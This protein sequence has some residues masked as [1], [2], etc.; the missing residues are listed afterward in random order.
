MTGHEPLP[1]MIDLSVFEQVLK[2]KNSLVLVPTERL[3]NQICAA[4]GSTKQSDMPA[5]R[6]PHVHSML[7]WLKNCWDEMHDL[8]LDSVTPWAMAERAQRLFFWEKAIN[9][10]NPQLATRFSRM[11]DDT[12][13]ELCSHY[14]HIENVP[15][16]TTSSRQFKV[17]SKTYAKLME[18][19]GFLQPH[20]CWKLLETNFKKH[21][22]HTYQCIYLYGFQSITPLE[23]NILNNSAD[24]CVL[25][26]PFCIDMID[27]LDDPNQHIRSLFHPK[28]KRIEG[29]DKAKKIKFNDP[30][31]ELTAA[32]TWA[33]KELKTSPNQRI[34]I[35]LPDLPNRLGEVY[36]AIDRAL[37]AS[38]VNIPVNFSAGVPLSE[39]PMIAG[40]LELLSSINNEKTLSYWLR[41]IYSPYSAFEYL[42]L[43]VKGQLEQQLRKK[44]LFS[45]TLHQ[46]VYEIE[47]SETSEDTSKATKAFRLLSTK[48]KYQADRKLTLLKFSQ[49]SEVIHGLLQKQNWPGTNPVSS[50]EYQQLSQWDRLME[51]FCGLDNLGERINSNGAVQTLISMANDHIFH[52][53]TP[54][55]SLQV[56]GLLDASGLQFNKVWVLGSDHKNL[57]KLPSINPLLPANYQKKHKLFRYDATRELVIARSLLQS[58]HANADFLICS[59]PSHRDEEQSIE[60]PLLRNIDSSCFPVSL[61]PVYDQQ[62]FDNSNQFEQTELYEQPNVPL[63]MSKEKIRGGAAILRNQFVCPFN[64]FAIHRLGAMPIDPP[65]KG[66]NKRERGILIHEILFKLWTQ[67]KNSAKLTQLS[68]VELTA[69]INQTIDLT[70]AKYDRFSS[71]LRG[72]R[73]RKLEKLQICNLIE[74]WLNKEKGREPFEVLELERLFTIKF[75]ELTLQLTV[76]RID[77]V[78]E[79]KL[80]IDYKTGTIKSRGWDPEQLREPQLPLYVLA[81]NPS[82]NGCAYAQLNADDIRLIGES[83]GLL[84]PELTEIDDWPARIIGWK[85][86]LKKLAHSFSSGNCDISIGDATAFKQQHFLLPL[87]RFIEY[88]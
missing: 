33:A 46:F 24:R 47:R 3:A 27:R 59:Y 23:R 19:N 86:G 82:S 72:P 66:I 38:D 26:D 6:A 71:S 4:W 80:I 48:T 15:S 12:Y 87:N 50:Y 14:L 51:Q 68:D 1:S 9:K 58:F 79:K 76:D 34:G 62:A 29:F 20:E 13:N 52:E 55:A 31:D 60:S 11:A 77:L 36:R 84:S 39:T 88:L 28:Y 65:H 45:L 42:S 41:I 63:E 30:Q 8:H 21:E 44:S 43:K 83:D 2:E 40:A 57:P 81:S 25:L 56:L 10:F 18:E 17:W 54:D 35:L 7:S 5:W 16:D 53:Q 78:G 85:R 64:S 69:Q 37:A 22:L 61:Q 70:F 74:A 75:G 32:A 73:Y 49:W 67:W